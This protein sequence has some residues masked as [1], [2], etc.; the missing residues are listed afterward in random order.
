MEAR[1][2]ENESPP[3]ERFQNAGPIERNSLSCAA[4]D[5]K[6]NESL[7][8]RLKTYARNSHAKRLRR[9]C[10]REAVRLVSVRFV[11]VGLVLAG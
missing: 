2:L 1:V 10:A 6:A 4:P 8:L 7:I 3:S 5:R 9:A 11:S